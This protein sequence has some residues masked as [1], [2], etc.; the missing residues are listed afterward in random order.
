MTD[1]NPPSAAR[2]LVARSRRP[3]RLVAA[4]PEFQLNGGTRLAPP[5]D[6]VPGAARAAAA[7][8]PR[9]A[10]PSVEGGSAVPAPAGPFPAGPFPAGPSTADRFRGA[11]E[12]R[13]RDLPRPAPPSGLLASVPP[14]PSAEAAG[15]ATAAG[16]AGVTGVAGVIGTS[17]PQPPLSPAGHLAVSAGRLLRPGD[18]RVPARPGPAAIPEVPAQIPG[19]EPRESSGSPFVERASRAAPPVTAPDQ[20]AAELAAPPPP[21]PAEQERG[22]AVPGQLDGPRPGTEYPPV[23]IGEIH[24]HVT[25][26]AAARPDPLALLAPYARGL[27]AR[28]EGPR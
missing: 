24:V 6:G 5:G 23:T 14:D 19:P 1:R 22:P 7:R 11:V 3:V 27:T 12:G 15:T 9:A 21:G 13:P 28:R 18:P 17:Q 2:M 25:E 26:P 4:P 20:G 10:A 16:M 8:S